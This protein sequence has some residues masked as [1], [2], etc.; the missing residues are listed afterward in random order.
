[1]LDGSIMVCELSRIVAVLFIHEKMVASA[2]RFS[3]DMALS[4]VYMS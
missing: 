4:V 1:M 3:V 2:Y